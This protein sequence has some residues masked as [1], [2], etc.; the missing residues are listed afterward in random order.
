MEMA[1]LLQ[2]Q[3]CSPVQDGGCCWVPLAPYAN[4]CL[5]VRVLAS[6]AVPEMLWGRGEGAGDCPSTLDTELLLGFQGE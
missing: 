2:T 3:V 1:P 6:P 5:A 4:G